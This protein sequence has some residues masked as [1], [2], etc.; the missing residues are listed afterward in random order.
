MEASGG[1]FGRGS[2]LT[3]V[4]ALLS[5]QGN[6]PSALVLDGEAGIGKTTLWDHGVDEARRRSLRV[7]ACRPRETETGL[8][9][10]ALGDLLDG[11]EERTF[12][13]LAEPQR[14]ALE[15]ALL[16]VVPAAPVEELSVF[17]ALLG[18]LRAL[19]IGPPLLVG[20]DD[21]QWADPGSAQAL[22]FAARRLG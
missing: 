12:A 9:F 18:V 17:R 1:I 20:I 13:A 10:V 22:E 4:E 5:D 16:R 11:V 3:A 21:V 19:A 14:L 7:L 6:L 15:A 8:P 2:E